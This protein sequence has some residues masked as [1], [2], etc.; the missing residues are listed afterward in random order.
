M[1]D[2]LYDNRSYRNAEACREPNPELALKQAVR[3]VRMPLSENLF[4]KL[5]WI[6]SEFKQPLLWRAIA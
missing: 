6:D 5:E 1:I 2:T 3:T 4:L